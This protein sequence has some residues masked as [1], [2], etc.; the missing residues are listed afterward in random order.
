M[1]ILL[2]VASSVLVANAF[3]QCQIAVSTLNFHRNEP[4]F[5]KPADAIG[6][7]EVVCQAPIGTPVRYAIS[8]SPG[9]GDSARQRR[10]RDAQHA[11]DY[12]LFLD[13]ARRV[14]WGDGT[15]G[16]T[17][18]DA[19]TQLRPVEVRRYPIYGRAHVHRNVSAGTYQDLITVGLDYY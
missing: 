8:S 17:L 13:P 5:V 10:L 11:L 4:Q 18:T 6:M 2:A 9:N 12:N 14:V 7:I 19:Y 16:T 1:K 15:I 3:A